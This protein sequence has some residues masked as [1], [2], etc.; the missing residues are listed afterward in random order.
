MP[1]GA[2]LDVLIATRVMGWTIGAGKTQYLTAEGLHAGWIEQPDGGDFED[3]DPAWS[4]SVNIA[5]AW[6]VV[7]RM[8]ALGF[9]W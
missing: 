4:P 9:F 2:E 3:H 5:D 8:H 1:A 6:E 7:D